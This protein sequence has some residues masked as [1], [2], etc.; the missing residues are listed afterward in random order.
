MNIFCDVGSSLLGNSSI[1]SSP[2]DQLES[3]SLDEQGEDAPST[4]T[5]AEAVVLPRFLTAVSEEMRSVLGNGHRLAA[6]GGLVPTFK[7][8]RRAFNLVEKRRNEGGKT[9]LKILL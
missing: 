8:G 1:V 9:A 3:L 4:P 7:S 5:A 2:L 6:S